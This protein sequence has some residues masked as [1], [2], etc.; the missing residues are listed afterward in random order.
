MPSKILFALAGATGLRGSIC[1]Q[2]IHELCFLTKEVK[3]VESQQQTR[4]DSLAEVEYIQ[5][6]LRDIIYND[7]N[8]RNWTAS[9]GYFIPIGDTI[10]EELF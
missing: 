4:D 2:S 10:N 9:L 6:M 8:V 1:G 7:V 3:A 5:V